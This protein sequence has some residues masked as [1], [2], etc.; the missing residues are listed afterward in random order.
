MVPFSINGIGKEKNMKKT[1]LLLLSGAIF[2]AA[3]A[4]QAQGMAPANRDYE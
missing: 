2:A 4:V 1:V 3:A